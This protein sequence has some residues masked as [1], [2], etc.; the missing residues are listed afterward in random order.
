MQFFGQLLLLILDIYVFIIILGAVI[1]WLVA[2]NVINLSNPQ[3]RN[4]VGALEKAT[5]PVFRPLR[6]F[7]PPIGGIDITP[8][9]V[10]F[11]I[12]I[13]KQVIARL[14]FGY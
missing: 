5:D 4:L 6:R 10:I 11:I 14:F 13:L 12:M 1:S 9:I 8:V 2:F 3:A 7:I